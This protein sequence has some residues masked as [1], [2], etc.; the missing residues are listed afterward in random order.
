MFFFVFL[1]V[2]LLFLAGFSISFALIIV[3][4]IMEVRAGTANGHEHDPAGTVGGLGG[5]W[6]VIL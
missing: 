2:F 4:A 3:V 1:F 5:C 6:S